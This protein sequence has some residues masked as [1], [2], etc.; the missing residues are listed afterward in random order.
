MIEPLNDEKE[1]TLSLLD[2][3]FNFSTTLANDVN[4]IGRFY[5]HTTSQSLSSDDFLNNN[6]ISIYTSSRENLRIVGVQSGTANVSLYNILATEVLR[7]SFEGTGMNNIQLPSLAQGVY[8]VR[9]S[10]DK[11]T[12]NKKVIIQ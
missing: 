3:D 11:G 12:I 5:L 2:T 4:G 6:N 1:I 10:T 8:I 7:S 9:L